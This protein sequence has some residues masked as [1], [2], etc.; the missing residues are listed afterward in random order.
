MTISKE[1]TT[2][3]PVETC[4]H[5]EEF[6]TIKPFED[7]RYAKLKASQKNEAVFNYSYHP[8]DME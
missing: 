7:I 4:K 3:I 6:S 2:V 5:E 1:N 8:I